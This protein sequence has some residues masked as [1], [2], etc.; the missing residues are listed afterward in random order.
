MQIELW[1]AYK[2]LWVALNELWRV[3]NALLGSEME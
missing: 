2:E 1:V 3:Y